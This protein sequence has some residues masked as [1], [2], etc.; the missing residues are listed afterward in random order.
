MAQDHQVDLQV[1]KEIPGKEIMK[2]I[3]FL[4]K[5]LISIIKKCSNIL[6]PGPDKLSWRHLKRIIK[7]N[8]YLN[9][10]INIANACIDIGH[11]LLHF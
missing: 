2:W 3:P 11:W 1:L 5:E 9:K 8:A 4:K 10:F 6:T 7:D